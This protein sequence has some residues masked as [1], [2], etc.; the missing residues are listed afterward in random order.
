MKTSAIDK[1][2]N[3]DPL[4]FRCRSK[5]TLV[6]EFSLLGIILFTEVISENVGIV[7]QMRFRPFQAQ[8]SKAQFADDQTG[9]VYSV[10]ARGIT[11]T[12]LR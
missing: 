12:K 6:L 5:D 4:F 1:R 9:A 11:D 2:A 3:I 8:E 10:L 7:N